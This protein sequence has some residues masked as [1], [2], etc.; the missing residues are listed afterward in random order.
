MASTVL[1]SL[2]AV[3]F[4]CFLQED[5]KVRAVKIA[6]STFDTILDPDGAGQTVAF[7]VHLIGKVI[8]FLRAIGNAEPTALAKFFNDGSGHAANPP[9]LGRQLAERKIVYRIRLWQFYIPHFYPVKEKKYFAH[10]S[11]G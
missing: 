2:G 5:G 9:F 1:L 7:L 8:N 3:F 6:E 10:P 11:F 4:L